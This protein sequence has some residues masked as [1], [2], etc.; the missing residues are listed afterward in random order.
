MKYSKVILIL[1]IILGLVLFNS[2]SVFALLPIPQLSTAC[3]LK[4]GALF[5]FDDGFSIW[6]KCPN[7]GRRVIILG[8]KGDKGD[9]GDPGIQGQQGIKGDKGDPGQFPFPQEV[10]FFNGLIQSN[11][12]FSPVVDTLNRKFMILLFSTGGIGQAIPYYSDDQSAWQTQDHWIT[13]DKSL[14]EFQRFFVLKGRYYKFEFISSESQNRV[15]I[16]GYLI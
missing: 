11:D 15:T 7:E 9:K 16:N 8:Q 2:S 1:P 14:P 4:S 3:E 10:T 5:A 6:K 12:Q 13:L